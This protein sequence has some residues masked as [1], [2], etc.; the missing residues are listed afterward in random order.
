LLDALSFTLAPSNTPNVKVGGAGG[1]DFTIF[2]LDKSSSAPS[3]SDSEAMLGSMYYD[4]TIGKIQCYEATG[5]GNCSA[6]PDIFVTISPEYPNAV[7]NGAIDGT[8]SSELCSYTLNINTGICDTNET[9]NFYRWTSP[10]L[11]EQT[12]SIY[13][14]YRLPESFRAFAPG[15]TSLGGRSGDNA[16]VTYQVYRDTGTSGVG[17]VACGEAVPIPTGGQPSWNTGWATGDA[18]PA[19]CG[20]QPGES[21]L[22]RINLTAAED[23]NAYISNLEFIFS[24]N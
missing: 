4:T 24:N 9:Y 12:H 1:D 2:T 16:N 23:A 21:I 7:M 22:F 8:M 5:W 20:F 14:T 10:E 6:R 3:A 19:N 11:I 13:V 17:L 18:D 15:S